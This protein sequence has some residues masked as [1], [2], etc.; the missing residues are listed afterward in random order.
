MRYEAKKI[1]IFLSRTDQTVNIFCQE[2]KESRFSLYSSIVTVSDGMA[3]V[4]DVVYV[5]TVT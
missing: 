1:R 5:N 3:D 4:V 2:K